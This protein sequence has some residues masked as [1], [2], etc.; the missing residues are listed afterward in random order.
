MAA[1]F[2]VRW[3]DFSGGDFGTLD[4]AF[5]DKDQY[6][7]QNVQRYNSGLVGPRAGLK[8]FTVDWNGAAGTHPVLG[9]LGFDAKDDML[10]VA[11]GNRTYRIPVGTGL[12]DPFDVYASSPTGFV[13]YAQGDR[14]LYAL[15]DGDLYKH[16]ESTDAVT[17]I[18][19]PVGV[20]LA[21]LTRWG[22]YLVGV[23]VDKPYRIWHSS[24]TIAGPQFDTW[25]ANNYLDVGSNLP[26]ECLRPLFNTLYAGKADGWW[27]ISG[28]L[29]EQA[30]VR[31]RNVGNGPVDER[32]A[33][34][35]TDNRVLYWGADSVPLWFNGDGVRHDED[36]R[37]SGFSTAFAADTVVATPTGKR[38]VMI[39]ERDGA[40]GMLLHDKGRWTTHLFDIPISAVAGNDVRNATGLP[41]GVIFMCQ[42]PTTIGDDV[43]IVTFQADLNRPA[44]SSDTWA[45]PKD[46]GSTNLVTGSFDLPAHWDGQGRFMRV[47]NVVVQFRKWPNGVADSWNEMRCLVKPFGIYEGGTQNTEV[48]V[49]TESAD[50]ADAAGTD[51]SIRFS[52]GENPLSTGFQVRFPVLRGVA[53]RSVIAEVEVRTARS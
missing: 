14:N 49:W 43:S 51:D 13:R 5:A 8:S 26:I 39:G 34:T 50:R 12:A 18:T 53:I 24:V 27:A 11:L 7:G 2:I 45:A 9:P 29:G 38:L 47:T 17:Q 22:Y 3:A 10:L 23:Q 37:L 16:N 33:T 42:R 28:I 6:S 52:F 35:T 4:P 15:I 36:Y 21:A 19:L 32:Q 25:G 40:A 20:K 44:H 41:E 46:A 30:A 48:K 31:Q 1:D